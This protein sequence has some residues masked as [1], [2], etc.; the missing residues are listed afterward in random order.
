[1]RPRPSPSDV[2]DWLRWWW[3]CFGVARGETSWTDGACYDWAAAQIGKQ[4]G[5]QIGGDVVH[6]SHGRVARAYRRGDGS[7]YPNVVIIEDGWQP[8]RH[9]RRSV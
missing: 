2:R 8:R 6:K 4:T 5:E 7:R 1:M 9:R 3:V